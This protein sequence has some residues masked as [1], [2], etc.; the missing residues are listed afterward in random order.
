MREGQAGDRFYVV[1]RGNVEVTVDGRSV[2]TLGRGDHFGEIALLRDVPR[3]AT[4]VSRGDAELYALDREEFVGV[5]TGDAA[6]LEAATAVI[7]S[8]LARG[9]ESAAAG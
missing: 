9:V 4:V 2:A 8:R 5:V 6:S 1:A 3:T 7:G